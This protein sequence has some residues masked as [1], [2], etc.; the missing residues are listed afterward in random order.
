MNFTQ[1]LTLFLKRKILIISCIGLVLIILLINLT[2]LLSSKDNIV[3]GHDDPKLSSSLQ[4]ADSNL[5]K[6]VNL[7]EGNTPSV[8]TLQ[9]EILAN[10]VY[11]D[12][13]D[14]KEFKIPI[15]FYHYI[16]DV[17]H[18]NSLT[19]RLS[20]SAETFE[21]QLVQVKKL[22]YTSITFTDL[23]NY[24]YK[25]IQLP[26][27][28]IILSFDDGYDNHYTQAYPLLTKYNL[29][30]NFAIITGNV[31]KMGYMTWDQVKILKAAGFEIDSH[32]VT[33]PNLSL[34]S[35][36]R[37]IYELSE[38][39]KVLDSLLHQNTQVLVY[40]S[41]KFNAEVEKAAKDQGYLLARSTLYSLNFDLHLPYE[42]PGLEIMTGFKVI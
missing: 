8:N 25:G 21:K 9:K 32:S 5:S 13:K 35:L 6:G 12:K 22:G 38:S 3:I 41:G 20:V 40:P 37:L 4:P 7:V 36:Q 14:I 39:K 26:S 1:S 23:I 34:A 31:G 27:K 24:I 16:R 10:P 17:P 29:K 15:Y 28:P 33:H 19:D 2:F 11:L 30:G 18:D 42:V